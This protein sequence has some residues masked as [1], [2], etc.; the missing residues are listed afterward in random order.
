MIIK[1]I[2]HSKL[3]IRILKKIIKCIIKLNLS[4]LNNYNKSFYLYNLFLKIKKIIKF[5]FFYNLIY[6]IITL[7]I[8][9]KHSNFQ[10]L[11]NLL[12]FFKF[13]SKKKLWP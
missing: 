6:Q 9:N 5:E 3:K 4:N 10:K 12:K 11:N 7:I 8:N 2:F 1:F 13:N